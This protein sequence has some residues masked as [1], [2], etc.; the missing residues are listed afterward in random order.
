MNNF[1]KPILY[2]ERNTNQ[3]YSKKSFYMYLFADTSCSLCEGDNKSMY[4]LFF[5]QVLLAFLVFEM[6]DIL[7]SNFFFGSITVIL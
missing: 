6:S 5:E 7:S 1:V 4:K 3:I 2:D